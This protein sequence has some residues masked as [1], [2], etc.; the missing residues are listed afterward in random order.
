MSRTTISD[1]AE[2]AGVSK[3]TVSRVLSGNYTHMRAAT[4]ERVEQAI[5]EL[6]FRPSSVARSLTSKR[7]Y[8]VGVIVS[9]VGNPFY[10]DVIRAVEDIGLEND[11]NAFLCSSGYDPKRGLS[12]IRLMIDKD[13]DGVLIMSS[14]ASEEWL[15]ELV[16]NDIPTVVLDWGKAQGPRMSSISVDF[17]SGVAEAAQYLYNLGHRRFAHVSGP[18]RLQTSRDRRDVF[19]GALERLGIAADDIA[20]AEG[21]M[22]MEGGKRAF[23][24][25]LMKRESPTAVFVANDLMAM[26]ILAEARAAGINVPGELSVIGL[27]DIWMAAQADPPLSTVALPRYEIGSL[28]MTILLDM[29]NAL[30]QDG[31]IHTQRVEVS[32]HLVVRNSTGPIAR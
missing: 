26:G 29:L 20:E 25:L 9:D 16:N 32:T 22:L 12:F 19:V 31:E 17:E 11:Y 18:M 8:T 1:V 23:R 30:D 27:D 4:R 21:N 6:K 2:A 28:A 24:Q 10:P 14:S 5:L 13:V 15:E 3:S 7:T